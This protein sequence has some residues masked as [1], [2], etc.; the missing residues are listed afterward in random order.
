MFPIVLDQPQTTGSTLQSQIYEQFFSAIQSGTLRPGSRLP[1]SRDISKQ[2]KVSRN[3]VLLA[4]DRLTD[5]GYLTTRVGAG[6]FVSNPLP[7]ACIVST[8]EAAPRFNDTSSRRSPLMRNKQDDKFPS[9]ALDYSA[10][11]RMIEHGPNKFR[12]NFW[13]GNANWRCFPLREWRKL[14]LENVSRTSMNISDYGPPEGILELRSAIADHVS[15]S[16]ALP[17]FPQRVVVTAGSQE[18]L[19]LICRLFVRPGTRV[20]VE[21]PCY[22][23][24]ALLFRSY[25]AELIPIPVDRDGMRSDALQGCGATLIYLTPSHQFPTGATMSLARRQEVLEWARRNGAYI[26]E[27]DYGSDFR[28]DGTPLPAITG[29]E[30]NRSVIYLG[31]FSKSMGS[32][33][34]TGYLIV[35][36]QLVDPILAAKAL[37]NYGHPWIEQVVLAEF[38]QNGGYQRHLRKIRTAYNESREAL[39]DSLLSQFGPTTISGG[40]AG[41]HIMWTLPESLPTAEHAVALAAKEGIG[42]FTP[43]SAG[44][45][46]HDKRRFERTLLMGYASLTPETIKREIARL[47][48]AFGGKTVNIRKTVST[49]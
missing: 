48:E 25:G 18:G 9:V 32:G 21:D 31:T 27:D 34:R 49:A 46:I 43:E 40:E 33:L 1:S 6:T 12:V 23:G 28:Y 15:V 30:N 5:E 47:A 17:T 36:E 26:V 10:P 11:L 41:M 29:M 45:Y 13:F 22:S 35:P 42:L 38:L 4:M 3:T 16:R 2:L 8:G 39:L 44:A 14:L 24:A 37:A 19:N 7:D 20:A